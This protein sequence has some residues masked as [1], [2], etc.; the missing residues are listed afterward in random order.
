M[1]DTSALQREQEKIAQK[2]SDAERFLAWIIT[3]QRD[4]DTDPRLAADARAFLERERE[5]WLDAAEMVSGWGV[6]ADEY[7]QEKHELDGDVSQCREFA[8][9][10]RVDGEQ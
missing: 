2:Q 1:S 3:M 4:G 10:F 9:A 8:D 7:Y 6:Y 5:R